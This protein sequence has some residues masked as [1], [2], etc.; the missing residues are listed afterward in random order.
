MRIGMMGFMALILLTWYGGVDAETY[1][2][3]DNRGMHFSEK[4][5]RP[6]RKQGVRAPHAATTPARRGQ[7]QVEERIRKDRQSIDDAQLPARRAQDQVEEQI[8]KARNGMSGH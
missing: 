1:Q 2:R 4:E 6:K 5:A 7:E 3:N 8:R